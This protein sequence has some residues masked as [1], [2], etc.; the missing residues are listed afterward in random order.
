MRF[1]SWLGCMLLAWCGL[2][3]FSAGAVSVFECEDEN[4]NRSF[5]D[6][7]PPGSKKVGTKEYTGTA[8]AGAAQAAPASLTLYMVPNCDSCD[9][10]KEF[11][12]VRNLSVEE[13]NV[14]DNPALQEELKAAAGDL[15]VPVLLVGDKVLTGYNRAELL[16]ALQAA[17]LEPEKAAAEEAATE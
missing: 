12:S 14:N 17:G 10:V 11:L 5:H 15:R 13:K 6:G 8:P 2:A 4:G 1:K 9:Q 16:A 3:A 7:C